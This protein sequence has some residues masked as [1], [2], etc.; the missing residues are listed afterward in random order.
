MRVAL[1]GAKEALEYVLG[2]NPVT[3]S[4]E[5]ARDRCREAIRHATQSMELGR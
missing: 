4:A 1:V 2:W 3:W 5:T